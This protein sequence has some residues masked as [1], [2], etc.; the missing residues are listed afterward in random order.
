MLTLQFAAD[1]CEKTL[2]KTIMVRLLREA[3]SEEK[4]NL[5]S[6]LTEEILNVDQQLIDIE[7]TTSEVSGMKST[8]LM[9]LQLLCN[10]IS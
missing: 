9:L 6:L 10:F 4:E 1:F 3:L 8:I 5:S 2:F 7:H